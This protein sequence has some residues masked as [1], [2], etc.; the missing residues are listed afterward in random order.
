MQATEQ[1]MRKSL[2]SLQ[3]QVQGL[4]SATLSTAL[5]AQSSTPCARIDGEGQYYFQV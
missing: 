1:S 4:Q 5:A 2:A 3:T